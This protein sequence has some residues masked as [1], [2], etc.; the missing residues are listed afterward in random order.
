MRLHRPA[1]LV[2]TGDQI[3]RVKSRREPALAPEIMCFDRNP[4]ATL[5][6]LNRLRRRLLVSI[7]RGSSWLPDERPGAEAQIPIYID[8]RPIRFISTAA[9]L[10]L[11]AEYDR[12]LQLSGQPSPVFDLP[13]WNP[14]VFET[15]FQLG[16]FATV[17]LAKLE[18]EEQA[19]V[20]EDLMTLR[21]LSGS[22]AAAMKQADEM[23]LELGRFIDPERELPD[24]IAIPLNSALSEAM[25]NVKAHAYTSGH[26]F[27][28][29]HVRRWWLT[30]SADRANR[31]LSIVIYDQGATIPVTYAHLPKHEAV[32]KFMKDGL[33]AITGGRSPYLS[34]AVHI[35]AA[36]KYGNSQTEL[37]NR[38]K[39]LPQMQDAIDAVKN[40]HLLVLSRGGRYL[41]RDGK[42]V[43]R[44]THAHS[45]GG[46]LIEWTVRLPQPVEAI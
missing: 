1:S 36:M 45:I 37:P 23:L 41:Y 24:E 8:F 14:G 13:E 40:G 19:V 29:R 28:F 21:F 6:L 30:G 22:N 20:N 11:A 34:D 4:D 31:V 7:R 44:K 12:A 18:E 5:D 17:G 46:T 3:R 26:K 32:K 43:E 42:V 39:G 27:Q 33:A 9:A 16:F 38:G 10:V 25:I 35:E 15:L 2:F